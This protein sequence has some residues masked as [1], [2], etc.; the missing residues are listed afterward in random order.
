MDSI[1]TKHVMIDT[2][3]KI[4][5]SSIDSLKALVRLAELKQDELLM[6]QRLMLPTVGKRVCGSCYHKLRRG[7]TL[8][9][10]HG[11]YMDSISVAIAVK[12]SIP[13]EKAWFI[14]TAQHDKQLV[15]KIL[16]A[17]VFR[18]FPVCHEDCFSGVVCFKGNQVLV[19]DPN[20]SVV[21]AD[22]YCERIP[23]TKESG[24]K[25]KN[26]RKRRASD[27][28]DS[29]KGGLCEVSILR[30]SGIIREAWGGRK[31]A[32]LKTRFNMD[33]RG[34]RFSRECTEFVITNDGENRMCTSCEVALKS[35]KYNNLTQSARDKKRERHSDPSSRTTSTY[36]SQSA[37]MAKTNRMSREIKILRQR[38]S[39]WRMQAA[40]VRNATPVHHSVEE[41]V[42]DLLRGYYNKKECEDMIFGAME[43]LGVENPLAL[44]ETIRSVGRADT[45]VEKHGTRRGMK[46]SPQY[47][48][49]VLAIYTV[50]PAATRE[51][52]AEGLLVLPCGKTLRVLMDERATVNKDGVQGFNGK[53]VTLL[54]DSNYGK[55]KVVKT[56]RLL[57]DEIYLMGRLGYNRSS[58]LL[59]VLSTEYFDLKCVQSRLS[60]Y[61]NVSND[62]TDESELTVPQ[63]D[64]IDAKVEDSFLSNS[65]TRSLQF[66]YED[67]TS[68]FTVI[69]H[70]FFVDGK[71]SGADLF[72]LVNSVMFDLHICGLETMMLVA[73]SAGENLSFMRLLMSN[74]GNGWRPPRFGD[75]LRRDFYCTNP[76]SGGVLFYSP[77]SVHLMKS[78]RNQFC[79][80]KLCKQ[81]NM[82]SE[83]GS[84]VWDCMEEC[85]RHDV[86]LSNDNEMRL[87]RMAYEAIF[88]LTSACRMKVGYAKQTFSHRSRMAVGSTPSLRDHDIQ[89]SITYM[90]EM[91]LLF[92]WTLHNSGLSVHSKKQPNFLQ[93]NVVSREEKKEICAHYMAAKCISTDQ[94]RDRVRRMHAFLLRWN[95]HVESKLNELGITEGKARKTARDTFYLHT[96]TF[97]TLYILMSCVM[98]MMDWID[99]SG[100][101][102]YFRPLRMFNQSKLEHLFS[103]AR[104]FSKSVSRD[105]S[106]DTNTYANSMTSI[107]VRK[108]HRLERATEKRRIDFK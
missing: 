91:D 50:S 34:V 4:N 108:G 19:M 41:I 71:V 99:K 80:S 45:L 78:C 89:G 39:Y 16:G 106:F 107:S 57:F 26:V 56:G 72:Q 33:Y 15:R 32:D 76:H 70:Y 95:K 21:R 90:R 97:Q 94:V 11:I 52:E 98:S 43:H 3:M 67:F 48:D 81:N 65:A 86:K 40:M 64:D 31:E 87:L 20:T 54:R 58:G 5:E 44:I 8:Y 18:R 66:M 79:N 85:Y 83:F 74:W 61:L 7:L 35:T 84:I 28:G 75:G 62:T 101:G 82:E 17:Y 104:A 22:G 96:M 37:K 92:T 55:G 42:D 68:K 38:E 29:T 30:C 73:D 27:D 13:P 63:K 105:T 77:C 36:A 49:M 6:D 23:T 47:I 25:K 12:N 59:G 2:V 88:M 46:Y 1:Q 102:A 14:T 60:S 24:K 53:R 93:N 9:D 100:G 10:V 51:A 103:Q 69:C